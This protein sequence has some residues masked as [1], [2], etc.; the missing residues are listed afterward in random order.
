VFSLSAGF[1]V[2][3]SGMVVLRVENG[4]EAFRLATNAIH[5]ILLDES[6]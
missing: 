4:R 5:F 3:I 1:E 2:F 6:S